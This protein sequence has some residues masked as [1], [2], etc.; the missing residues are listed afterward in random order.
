MLGGHDGRNRL[1]SVET[2]PLDADGRVGAWS[3]TTPLHDERS[4]TALAVA[5]GR[6]YV[7]GG[8][9]VGGALNSVEMAEQN[10]DGQL[11]HYEAR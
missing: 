1:R 10:A 8:M 3:F 11:G 9:G 6:V 7:L 4:A 2:A 5:S